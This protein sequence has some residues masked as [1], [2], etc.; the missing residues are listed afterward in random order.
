[1]TKY[2]DMDREDLPL[3]G[4]GQGHTEQQMRDSALIGGIALLG[5]IL[6]GI[7]LLVKS[8]VGVLL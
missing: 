7:V 1:M 3:I 8:C 5:L 2:R 4:A 6:V